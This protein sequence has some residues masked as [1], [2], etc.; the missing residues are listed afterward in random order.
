M[1]VSVRIDIVLELNDEAIVEHREYLEGIHG[2]QIASELMSDEFL[3]QE[4]EDDFM[5]CEFRL[6]IH[7]L[8]D[9]FIPN[10]EVRNVY[11]Y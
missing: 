4:I 8:I 9:R 2:K 3:R 7:S 6:P 5:N 11:V 10:I 1:I